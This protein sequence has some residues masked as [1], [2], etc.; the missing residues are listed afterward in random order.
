MEELGGLGWRSQNPPLRGGLGR[1][2]LMEGAWEKG[3]TRFILVTGDWRN[4]FMS[5]AA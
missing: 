5:Q 2:G 1:E 4:Q 3:E